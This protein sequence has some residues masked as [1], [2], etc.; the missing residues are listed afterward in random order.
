M[1]GKVIIDPYGVLNRKECLELGF[2]Y[3]QLG[4]KFNG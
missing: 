1:K 2:K 4:V 3:H